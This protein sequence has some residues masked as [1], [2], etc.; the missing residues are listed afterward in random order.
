ML[1]TCLIAQFVP[2][3]MAAFS[4]VFPLAIGASPLGP[5]ILV[6]IG[7]LTAFM[8]PLATPSVAMFM[9]IGGYDQ[10]T[11]FK[12]SWLPAICM[13]VLNVLWVMTIFPAFP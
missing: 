7:A 12:M 9:A 10:K 1:I 13:L 4:I 2:S 5:V 11:M 6:S 3:A 8:T